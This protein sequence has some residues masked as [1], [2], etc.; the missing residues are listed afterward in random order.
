MINEL[1]KYYDEQQAQLKAYLE[2]ELKKFKDE[3]NR[4]LSQV[5]AEACEHAKNLLET[6][7]KKAFE[8]FEQAK[9]DLDTKRKENY[10]E[11][12]L[13]HIEKSAKTTLESSLKFNQSLFESS[14]SYYKKQLS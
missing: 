8:R 14:V 1:Q 11:T 9:N 13:G 3:N 10:P 2:N 7:N 12:L 4:Y 6:S 5:V